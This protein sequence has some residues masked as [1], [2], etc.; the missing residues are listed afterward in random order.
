MASKGRR[1]LNDFEGDCVYRAIRKDETSK[2]LVGKDKTAN[3]PITDFVGQGRKKE[4]QF[5]STTSSLQKAKNIAHASV[6]KYHEPVQV[7]KVDVGWIKDHKPG[8][9]DQAYNFCSENNRDKFLPSQ[10]QKDHAGKMKEV[11]FP[12]KI[13]K[14]AVSKVCTVG[15][16]KK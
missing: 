11:Y 10:K 7:V 16:K 9:A 13:P 8:L 5:I 6:S 15:K 4:S 12:Q 2:G 14:E 3:L 1:G